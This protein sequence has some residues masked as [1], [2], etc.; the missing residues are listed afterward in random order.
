MP[1]W[2]RF[3]KRIVMST[4]FPVPRDLAHD[5]EHPLARAFASFTEA[6]GS[7]ERTYG[8]LQGQVTHLRQGLEVTNRDLATSLEE[9]HRIRE[10][11][12]RI[13][14]GLP[15]GVLVVE[16]GERIST[17]NPEA[18]RLLGQS[19]EIG[20]SLA[21]RALQRARPGPRERRRAGISALRLEPMFFGPEFYGPVFRRPTFFRPGFSASGPPRVGRHPPRLAGANSS[22]QHFGFHLARYQRGQEARTRSRA[23]SASARPG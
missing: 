10:C 15:C 18:A 3:C 13:L 22:A 16:A 14:E 5:S 4:I 8:Q 11:L 23:H 21:G 9:N 1:G 12:R 7:L 19:F 20:R 17:L 6:A 2:H